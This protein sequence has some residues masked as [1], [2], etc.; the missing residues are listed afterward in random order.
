MRLAKGQGQVVEA[1]Q[2]MEDEDY[3][4]LPWW[5]IVAITP[6]CDEKMNDMF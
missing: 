6:L 1:E 4:S 3:F 2:A 5:S